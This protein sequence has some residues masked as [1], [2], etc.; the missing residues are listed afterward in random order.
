MS[1]LWLLGTYI[2]NELRNILSLI[3]LKLDD[4]KK[5]QSLF[6]KQLNGNIFLDP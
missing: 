4:L 5:Y 2:D 1:Q 6:E 3:T